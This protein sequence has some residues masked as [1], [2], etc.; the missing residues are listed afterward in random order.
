MGPGFL[1]LS[2]TFCLPVNRGNAVGRRWREAPVTPGASTLLPSLSPVRT[3]P[4]QT[5]PDLNLG[6]FPSP[7]ALLQKMAVRSPEETLSAGCLGDACASAFRKWVPE[8]GVNSVSA[9]FEVCWAVSGHTASLSHKQVRKQ[10]HR[11]RGLW[12]VGDKRSLSR[13][14]THLQPAFLEYIFFLIC[15]LPYS[16]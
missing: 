12:P 15:L 7:S 8:C 2:H 14:G 13:L 16:L 6:F 11:W 4:V 9:E 5:V 3:H 1:L 10:R